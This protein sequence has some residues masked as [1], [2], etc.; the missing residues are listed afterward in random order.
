MKNTST[1]SCEGFSPVYNSNSKI[2]ILGSYPSVISRQYGFYYGNKKNRFWQI[3]SILFDI[4]L[5]NADIAQKK[6]FLFN[7]GIALYDV[8]HSCVI[9]GSSDL[10]IKNV[11][12]SDI[13]SILNNSDI[14]KIFLNGK[15]AQ[16]LFLKHF[17][18]YSSMAICLPSTSP[19][20]A[21]KSL[22][23][24]VNDYKIILDYIKK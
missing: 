14:K 1:F 23:D 9:T 20:N 15:K 8:V 7:T 18:F 3:M 24:L 21:K 6:N 13:K 5:I 12:V 10:S 22:K 19:A 11:V 4:D 2:I 17:P 16:E